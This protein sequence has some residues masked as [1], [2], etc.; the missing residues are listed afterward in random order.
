MSKP[1]IHVPLDQ[2]EMLVLIEAMEE[3]TSPWRDYQDAR[4]PMIT[5]LL[6][7]LREDYKTLAQESNSAN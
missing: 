7:R 6:E 2:E 1:L 4:L 5:A 3:I